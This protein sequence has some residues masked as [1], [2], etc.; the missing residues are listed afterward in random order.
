[1]APGH[2]KYLE[3]VTQADGHSGAALVFLESPVV[4]VRTHRVQV[5]ALAQVVGV[6]QAERVARGIVA[7]QTAVVDVGTLP[8]RPD[9]AGAA[10]RGADAQQVRVDARAISQFPAAQARAVHV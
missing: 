9:V 8:G 6:A 4:A 1:P 5:G 3:A 10:D 7:S 2:V